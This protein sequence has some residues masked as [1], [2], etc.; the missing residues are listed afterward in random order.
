MSLKY[1]EFKDNERVFKFM[2]PNYSISL[3]KTSHP[4]IPE[5]EF[6]SL[7][8][9]WWKVGMA[10]N[11]ESTIKILVCIGTFQTGVWGTQWYKKW[12]R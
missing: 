2:P 5:Q 3:Q 1:L 10:K 4:G 9:K 11:F 6:S 8:I 12:A 7:P